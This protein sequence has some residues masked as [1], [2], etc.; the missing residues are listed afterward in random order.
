MTTSTTP[1]QRWRSVV[2]N[3]SFALNC[4]LLFLLFFE[5]RLAL[6]AWVQV[7]GRMHPLLLH[8]PLV[9]IILYAVLVVFIRE[10]NSKKFASSLLL[11]AALTSVLSAIMGLFLSKE[12]GYDADA[13]WWHKWGGVAIS[14][15]SLVWYWL[16]T[17]IQAP[18]SITIVTSIAAL[19]L[20]I[21]TGHLGASITHGEG[22]LLAPVNNT[23]PEETI[24]LEDAEVYKHM[25][26][27]ILEQ[28]CMGCHNSKKAKGELVMETEAL[29]LK[30]GKN[31]KLWDTTENDLGLML[32][33]IHLPLEQ[34]KH[35]PPKNKPQLTEEEIAVLTQW[36]RRNAD[37]TLR[38]ADLGNDDTLYKIAQKKFSAAE[39]IVYDFEEAD[40]SLVS[41]LNTANRVVTPEATGSPALTVSFFNADLFSNAQLNEL[42]DIKKQVVSLNLAQMPLKDDDMKILSEFENLRQL[43]LSFTGISGNSLNELKKL[44]FLRSLGLSGTNVAASHLD[45]LQSFPALTTLYVWNTPV[46]TTGIARLQQKFKGIRFETGFKNDTTILKLSPPV[47][48]S[49]ERIIVDTPSALQLKHYIKDAIIRYTT[50]G[51]EP[52]SLQSRVFK[53]NEIINN[54]TT[55]KA[56]AYKPG[57]LSSDLLE[58]K[59]FKNS[60]TPDSVI[61]LTT[62]NEKYKDADG[63]LLTDHTVGEASYNIGGWVAFREN[64]MECLLSFSTLT[65]I[66]SVG[67]SGL[68]DVGSYIFPPASVQI[69][70]GIDSNHLKL[71]GQLQ[72][73]QPGKSLP[74]YTKNFECTF[75]AVAVKYVK[76]I[77]DPVAKLPAWHQGKGD[78][79]WIFLDELLVN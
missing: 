21:V 43:N 35:M 37:F 22:F 78:K 20:I 3:V 42:K 15:F 68:V 59:F 28:K 2:F 34:K 63:K 19:V 48:L 27:P 69:W 40:A 72:P 12:E 10:E 56:K 53:G 9:L 57:W 32:Q 8:F 62:P 36:I 11:I 76:I 46:A 50:D 5:T 51:S 55:V 52:D 26:R 60:Y 33:R 25:V 38:V 75:K 44:K 67:I 73:E 79:A 49:G 17:K 47:S 58:V 31:G 65:T 6:P 4:M 54:H 41:K 77:A 29:L 45:Q 23:T 7:I 70:G 16:Q 39:K 71:L 66:K 1:N 24:A 64:R 13:L 18:R 30:G 74:S 14:W 61:Y